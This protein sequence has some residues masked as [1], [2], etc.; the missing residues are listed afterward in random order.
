MRWIIL[1]SLLWSGQAWATGYQE[2]EPRQPIVGTVHFDLYQGYLIVA[3]GSAGPVKGLTFLIDTGASPTVLDPRV[4]QKLHLEEQPA[5][6]AVLGGRVQAERAIVPSLNLGPVHR[7]NLPVLIEDLSFLEKALPFRV[8]A[9]V[10]LDVLG[11]GAFLI[12][13]A[14][15]TIQFG[16]YPLLP[17]SI[18][19]RRKDGLVIVD[20]EVNGVPASL[21]VDTGASA[22]TLFVR[23]ATPAL[24]VTSIGQYK[25]TQLRARTVRLGQTEFRQ[26]PVSVVGGG[27]AYA[28]DGLMSPAALGITRVAIDVGR[29]TMGFGR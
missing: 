18:A 14:A 16:P 7:Q 8:D 10:G 25:S 5:S 11:E 1:M 28:F 12:D 27:A 15:H 22:L 19:L 20:A 24:K 2:I 3:R 17:N 26:E 29:G 23:N 6:I 21:L 13:Y 9:V 4:A